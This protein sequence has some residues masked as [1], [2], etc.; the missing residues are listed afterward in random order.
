VHF[1]HLGFP[2]VGDETYGLKANKRLTEA[3]GVTVPRQMLHA[4][5]LTFAHPKN[6]R[7]KSFTAPWPE[8]FKQALEALKHP[9]AKKA[10]GK[11]SRRS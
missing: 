3:T 8:D 5:K 6:G 1:Q 7:N 2:V 11:V 9:D 4:Y 10:A